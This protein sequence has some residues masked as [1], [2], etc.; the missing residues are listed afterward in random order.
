VHQPCGRDVFAACQHLE[1]L[2]LQRVADQ[3]RG[4]FVVGHVHGRLAAA[5]RVV[6]H[7]G[8]VVVDQRIRVDHL[9]RAG[10]ARHRVLAC[11]EQLAAA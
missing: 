7:A 5:E 9:D 3:Q 2:G 10:G 1:G 11:A 4:R 8:H 6:V